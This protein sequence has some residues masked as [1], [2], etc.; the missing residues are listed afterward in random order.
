[1]AGRQITN[2]ITEE[3]ILISQSQEP[4]LIENSNEDR[5]TSQQVQ[6][7]TSMKKEM[8]I[9]KVMIILTFFIAVLC[10]KFV[11]ESRSKI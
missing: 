9:L 3:E 6:S 11:M 5:A 2:P 1:M 7:W 10:M 4:S 8:R